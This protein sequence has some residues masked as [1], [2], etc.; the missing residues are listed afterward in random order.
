VNAA[1]R[2]I[3]ENSAPDSLKSRIN[4]IPI[5]DEYLPILEAQ[6]VEPQAV[7]QWK[8][9]VNRRKS[10]KTREQL[11][12]LWENFLESYNTYRDPTKISEMQRIN[13]NFILRNY[14][15]Q[16]AINQAELGNYEFVRKLLRAA[17][18]PFSDTIDPDLLKPQPEHEVCTSLS[19][20]S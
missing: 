13:P 2:R 18:N 20:S 14:L 9:R 3:L 6:G 11:Q 12:V 7:L 15:M 17:V 16:R 8:R 1:A 5:P 19:C 10:I 4:S